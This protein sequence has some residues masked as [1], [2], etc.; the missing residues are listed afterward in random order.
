MKKF[1]LFILLSLIC[2]VIV[3]AETI[4]LEQQ[5]V[6][7]GNW[8]GMAAEGIPTGYT[9][10]FYNENNELIGEVE[11]DP[12]LVD[13]ETTLE[14]EKEGDIIPNLFTYYERDSKGNVICK[15][16]KNF[17]VHDGVYRTWTN[18]TIL[19]RY[20]YND[21]KQLTKKIIPSQSITAKGSIV[22][23]TYDGNN[24]IEETTFSETGAWKSSTFYSNFEEG[25][26]NLP[27]T[28]IESSKSGSYTYGYI[29]EYIYND[30]K[31]ISEYTTYNFA[32]QI[33]NDNGAVISAE[34]GTPV[35]KFV[36]NYT[37]NF[38]DNRVEYFWSSS[39]NS[40]KETKK[41]E[42]VADEDADVIT[43]TSYSYA[44]EKW[45]RLGTPSQKVYT[46][47]D[48]DYAP[49]NAKLITDPNSPNTLTI[50]ATPAK[51]EIENAKYQV[52]R[53]GDV[54][55]E[56]TL[57]G[58]VLEFTDNSLLNGQYVYCIQQKLPNEIAGYNVSN[59]CEIE[60][61]TELKAPENVKIKHVK[62]TIEGTGAS[63]HEYHIMQITWD[64]PNT[65]LEVLGYNI[66]T[67]F[68]RTD[69]NPAPLNYIS[70]EET[71]S[72]EMI[73][74]T[75]YI[76]KW[77][78]KSPEEPHTV[79]VEA[80]YA[81]G[82]KCSDAYCIDMDTESEELVEVIYSYDNN[83]N[84]IEADFYYY[85]EKNEIANIVRGNID[86]QGKFA[87]TSITEFNYTI[88]T[89]RTILDSISRYT[90][91][92]YGV[93]TTLGERT[94]IWIKSDG[95]EAKDK[96]LDMPYKG[97]K[98]EIVYNQYY[99]T[100]APTSCKIALVS[101]TTNDYKITCST[102]SFDIASQTYKI[103]RNGE[104]IG[105]GLVPITQITFTDTNVP[106]GKNIYWV[107]IGATAANIGLNISYNVSVEVNVEDTNPTV[108][109]VTTITEVVN[110]TDHNGN[111]TL[112]ISWNKAKNAIGYNVY[113][114][115]EIPDNGS[116]YLTDTTFTYHLQSNKSTTIT[117]QICIE[118]LNANSQAK[119]TAQTFVVT[120]INENPETNIN[121]SE[122]NQIIVINTQD[123]IEII[124]ANTIHSSALYTINGSLILTTQNNVINTSNINSGIYLLQIR[125]EK[126]VQTIKIIK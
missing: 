45:A 85:N 50:T 63:A 26:E 103:Y 119:S 47:F 60:F 1:T 68:N 71:R 15:K 75:V 56:A 18:W 79:Y 20:E 86:Q 24:L 59:P 90:C 27:K 123:Y 4:R 39:S 118:S 44:S 88:R 117:K 55:G 102:P 70:T 42:Y 8:D 124:S 116:E 49:T 5:E 99:T 25:A 2:N 100:T 41:T 62:D 66:Y 46:T 30:A 23:Y 14:I 9:N 113:S 125:T 38:L 121:N 10:F 94:T 40:W 122:A 115:S 126:E 92:P 120:I 72:Y 22:Y 43:I 13:S 108:E 95:E 11:L 52:L 83:G 17:T 57:N 33:K 96:A 7:L 48:S 101:K 91:N 28:V 19:E 12:Y 111:A 3:N 31:Q 97:I 64:A 69:N 51:K 110:E 34:K 104:V 78:K 21:K 114:D 107:Q 73:S 58:S 53:N 84:P 61:Q 81:F 76:L 105:E 89:T 93:T 82:N 35:S 74:D 29:Y 109:A 87:P 16:S 6:S 67:D 80:I 54:I 37:G 77:A 36:Y 106:N 112:T 98:E 32:N 65:D